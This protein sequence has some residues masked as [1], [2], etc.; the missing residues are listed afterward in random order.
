MAICGKDCKFYA[1]EDCSKA[2]SDESKQIRLFD[3][4]LY[5]SLF[6]R[7]NYLDLA[8]FEITGDELMLLS[9]ECSLEQRYFDL[10]EILYEYS[11][12]ERASGCSNE[13]FTKA[14]F[15]TILS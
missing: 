12:E 13:S 15:S 10:I 5:N 3:E 11:V 6:Y 14:T 2:L 7:K 9:L 1:D 4:G 8:R